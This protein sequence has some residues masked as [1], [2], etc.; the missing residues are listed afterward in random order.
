MFG[1]Q[2][3]DVCLG[4][5]GNATIKLAANVRCL[6]KS[7]PGSSVPKS[8]PVKQE[9]GDR[10]PNDRASSP[11]RAEQKAE[12]QKDSRVKKDSKIPALDE[13]VGCTIDPM[14]KSTG[15]E[16]DMD[17]FLNNETTLRQRT[18]AE[19]QSSACGKVSLT[20]KYDQDSEMLF[21]K[22]HEAKG[23][24]GG[25]LPDPPDPYVKLYL[26][27]DRS[28]KSKRK[29][30]VIKDSVTPVFEEVRAMPKAK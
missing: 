28:K 23:L 18:S 12:D 29:S 14:V 9:Y 1:W 20:L 16:V 11:P 25:D 24:P 7:T 8:T 2:Y 13:V 17:T 3:G 21:V 19:V 27:P 4:P 5:G 30:E 10:S 6:K 22:L 15:N 26:L